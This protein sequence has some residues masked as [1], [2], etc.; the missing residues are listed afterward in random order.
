MF[1]GYL[2]NT[3]EKINLLYTKEIQ[4]VIISHQLPLLF[5]VITKLSLFFNV[6]TKLHLRK[7]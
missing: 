7:I 2:L 5:Y 1:K 4:R 3:C 6:N